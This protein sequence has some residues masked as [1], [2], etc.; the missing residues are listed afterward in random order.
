MIIRVSKEN[1]KDFINNQSGLPYC[2]QSIED[3]WV[4]FDYRYLL[5]AC[6]DVGSPHIIMIEDDFL[7]LDEWYQRTV[8]ALQDA[9]IQTHLR[10]Y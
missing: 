7:P 3:V 6:Y 5:N 9:E 4:M 8:E 10:A 2:R 1:E